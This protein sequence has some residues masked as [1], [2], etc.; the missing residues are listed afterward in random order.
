MTT[1]VGQA[2]A[3]WAATTVVGIAA[4]P[5]ARTLLP[6]LP[7]RGLAFARPLGLLLVGY[8]WWFLVTAG[9]LPNSRVGVIVALALV[10][11]GGAALVARDVPGWLAELRARRRLLVGLETL[12]LVA[13]VLWALYRA[14]YPDITES[15][16]EKMMEMA[17]LSAIDKSPDFPPN[18]PWMSGHSISYYYFGYLIAAMLVKLTGLSRF[19]AYNLVVPMTWAMTLAAAFSLGWALSVL[20]P[21]TTRRLRIL[22]GATTAAMLAVAGNLAGY[23]ELAY[24]RGWLPAR[25]FDFMNIRN[26]TVVADACGEPGSGYGMGG[27]FPSRFMWWWRTSRVIRDGCKDV[28]QEYPFFSFLLAD[29]HPHLMTLPYALLALAIG[30]ALLLGAGERWTDQRFRAPMWWLVPL[31][32]GALGFLNTWDL[33]TYG[34]VT[35]ACWSLW[36][37][38]QGGRGASVLA[39][40]GVFGVWLLGLAIVLYLPFYLAFD[41]QA[42]G[43]GMALHTSRLDHW[44]VHFLPLAFLAATVVTLRL[45]TTAGARGP[46]RALTAVAVTTGAVAAWSIVVPRWAAAGAETH[47]TPL[48]PVLVVGLAAVAL[49]A[50]FADGRYAVRLGV[51][52][53]VDANEDAEDRAVDNAADAAAD[54]TGHAAAAFALVCIAVGLAMAALPEFIYLKD[55]FND[56]MNTIFKF[57]FQAW[58]LLSIGGG[59]ALTAVWA[60]ARMRPAGGGRTAGGARQRVPNPGAGRLVWTAAFV[61][62]AAMVLYTPVAAVFNRTDGLGWVA[63]RSGGYRA[64]S[65]R[66]HLDGIRYWEQQN[67]DDLA[68]GRW[69]DANAVG[70]PRILEAATGAYNLAGRIAMLTGFPTVLGNDNHEA[71]WGRTPEQIRLRID[72]VAAFYAQMPAGAMK[73]M[74]DKYAVRYV[75]VG[76]WERT[77]YPDMGPDIDDRLATFMTPA[78]RSGQTTVWA[79]NPDP[80]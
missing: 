51:G 62:L 8:T 3:W 30:L 18:D 68:A 71:Q 26:L 70:T 52:A 64:W 49:I 58:V 72:D 37:L 77:K 80:Q 67:P 53:D 45:R 5:I 56:R 10:G 65:D 41:T 22:A 66:L 38:R 57:F 12:Y 16:G 11:G 28:I 32:I 34:L 6:T 20:T 43:I 59:Y 15:G 40:I 39:D 60:R 44:S 36:R 47:W 76:A 63:F 7:D 50:L 78:F 27:I 35:G 46:T 74:L 4:A 69:L 55:V 23:L 54:D 31:C 79:L 2:L 9:V 33:P 42:S 25:A 21:G 75:I 13:L 17:F 29:V 73:E 1:V 61:V 19:V 14:F 24:M 48:T